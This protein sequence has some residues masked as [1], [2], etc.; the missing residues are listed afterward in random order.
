MKME[1][2]QTENGAAGGASALTDVL[3]R[4]PKKG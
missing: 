4:L 3:E 2:A 1:N